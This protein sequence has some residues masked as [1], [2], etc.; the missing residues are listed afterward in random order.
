MKNRAV[1]AVVVG[2]LLGAGFYSYYQGYQ[3]QEKERI[4]RQKRRQA[5]FTLKKTLE[6]DILGFS[7]ESAIVVKD[8]TRKWEISHNKNTLFPAASLSK[9]QVMYAVFQGVAEGIF[10]VEDVS[11]LRGRD[12]ASGSGVLKDMP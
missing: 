3:Q 1:G 9:L 7:G 10:R 6:D 4:Q 11:I 2:V 12:K 8:L 5:W